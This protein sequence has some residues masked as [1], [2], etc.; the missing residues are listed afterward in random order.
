M[1][2]GALYLVATPIGNLDDLSTRVK[3][4]LANADLIACEDTRVTGKLLHFLNLQKSTISYREENEKNLAPEL[5]NRI[6]NGENIALVSDAGHPAIS[7]P[8]FRLVRECRSRGLKVCP[9]PGPMA[10]ISALA[11][12]GLPTDSF[13]FVGFLPPKKSARQKFF[14]ENK[15]IPYTLILYESRHRIL[16]A[17]EDLIEILGATRTICVAR[18]ITKLHETFNVGQAG[19]VFKAVS[20]QSQKGEFVI[21]IAK[22]GYALQ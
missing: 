22:E 8:G 9:V 11:A 13:L 12:S 21:L 18:E 17:L 1:Q 19:N 16:K 3:N 15:A 4:T 10:G 7:D 2:E 6:A 5:A 14:S 20:Q